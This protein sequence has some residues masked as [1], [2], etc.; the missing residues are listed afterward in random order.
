MLADALRTQPERARGLAGIVSKKTKGNPFYAKQFLRL[1]HER[2]Y[3]DLDREAGAW[4]WDEGAIGDCPASENVVDFLAENLDRFPEQTRSLL[5]FGAC[6]GAGFS[7]DDLSAVCGLSDDEI[8]RRLV[9]A[10][11][12][13][14][15]IPTGKDPETGAPSRYRFAHD[16]F[17]QVFYTALP[18][19]L[20]HI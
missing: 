18:L 13:E 7:V 2:G 17:Q 1:C 20:I 3:L 8:E 5:S 10:S 12:Q 4:R 15:V 6:I 9:A 11:A 14:A 16:R 19:S